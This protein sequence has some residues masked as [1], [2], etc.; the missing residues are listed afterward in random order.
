VK[1][2]ISVDLYSWCDVNGNNRIK[3]QIFVSNI[4]IKNCK[5]RSQD[6]ELEVHILHKDAT[7][8]VGLLGTSVFQLW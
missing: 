6:L 7:V 8:H 3:L 2:T 4:F 5:W 1:K